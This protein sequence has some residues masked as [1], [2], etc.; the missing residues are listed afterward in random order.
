MDAVL[1]AASSES[2]GRSLLEQLLGTLGDRE[3]AVRRIALMLLN[4]AA[5]HKPALIRPSLERLLPLLYSET[6]VKVCLPYSALY[7][8]TLPSIVALLHTDLLAYYS[9]DVPHTVLCIL[10]YEFLLIREG[11]RSKSL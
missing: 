11:G 8:D 1:R 4:A 10:E 3:L 6:K 9:T 7:R 5:H 2:G